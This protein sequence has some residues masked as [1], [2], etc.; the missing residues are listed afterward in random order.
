MS[1]YA[2]VVNTTTDTLR[3]RCPVCGSYMP[4]TPRGFRTCPHCEFTFIVKQRA[5]GPMET[6]D[7]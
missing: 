3:L 5:P 1:E 6:K 7:N 4:A 2:I